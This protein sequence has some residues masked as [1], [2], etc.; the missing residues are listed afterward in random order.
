MRKAPFTAQIE[1]KIEASVY[2]SECP[3]KVIS[4]ITNVIDKCTADFR[5]GS[6]VVGRAS[7]SESLSTIYEQVRSRASMGVLRRMLLDNKIADTTY[8]F[9]NKQ[10]ASAGIVVVIED[11]KE[12]P[13][14]PIRV[15]I[16]CEE[17]DM[18]ICWLAPGN[19]KK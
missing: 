15:N 16:D 19:G 14:G 11:V 4:A 12:S 5:Y 7:G 3:E 8:F 9:L 2:P 13:L 17:L 1:L 10:A 6:R 18:L